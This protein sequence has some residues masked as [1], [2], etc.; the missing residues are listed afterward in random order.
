MAC[1]RRC[2]PTARLLLVLAFVVTQA[3]CAEGAQCGQGYGPDPS[4]KCVRCQDRN[5]LWCNQASYTRCNQCGFGYYL[6]LQTATCTVCRNGCANCEVC[7]T[8]PGGV[9]CL[10]RCAIANCDICPNTPNKCASCDTGYYF[11]NGPCIP[12]ELLKCADCEACAGGTGCKDGRKCIR[13]CKDRNCDACGPQGLCNQ[14]GYGFWLDLVTRKCSPCGDV[15]PGCVSCLA[16]TTGNPA[17]CQNN[18][19]YC[20]KC[21]SGYRLRNG[22]CR[23]NNI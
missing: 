19:Y 18:K 1:P 3:K 22:T 7:P 5:C 4:G 12:C 17:Q 13:A 11:K 10:R 9:K 20:R 15:M 21:K 16:C 23:R 2:S 6:I 14:C 8:C